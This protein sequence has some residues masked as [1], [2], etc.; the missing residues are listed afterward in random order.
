M[1]EYTGDGKSAGKPKVMP[2]AGDHPYRGVGDAAENNTASLQPEPFADILYRQIHNILGGANP[3]QYLCL[4]IPGQALSAEDFRYDYKNKSPKGPS[5]EANESRLANKMFDPCRMAGADNGLT[6]PYQYQS[7]L[8]MLTPMLN[9]KAADA[10]SKLR[11]LLM[12]KYDYQFQDDAKQEYT[13]QEVFF[14]LY[15]EWLKAKNDWLSEQN[16]KKNQLWQEHS[17]T[18][19]ASK[20]NELY[21]EWYEQVAESRIN[22]LNEKMAKVISVFTPNDMEI[23]EGVLD[24]GSGAELQ[25]ARQALLNA[26]KL[27][28]DGGYVYPVNLN[29]ANWFEYLDTSFTADDLLKNP[30][31]VAM[32][33]ANLSKR[34]I[35][36][37]SKI[38]NLV[39]LIPDQDSLKEALENISKAQTDLDTSEKDLEAFYTDGI[40]ACMDVFA[41]IIP[42]FAESGQI[43]PM[44]VIRKIAPGVTLKDSSKTDELIAAFKDTN[45]KLSAF[46]NCL[47]ELADAS[48]DAAKLQNLSMLQSMLV[49][50]TAQLK[51]VNLEIRTLHAQML[52]SSTIRPTPNTDGMVEDPDPFELTVAPASVPKGYTQIT[53]SASA[54][55]MDQSS[56][57]MAHA[58]VSTCGGSF[59]FGG[60]SRSESNASSRISSRISDKKTEIQIGMNVT[61][62]GIERGWFQPGVFY[63]TKDMFNVTTQRIAPNPARPYTSMD[64]QRL[65]DM[66]GNMVFPCYPV[67][68]V[69]ARDIS[70]RFIS[71][72]TIS[73]DFADTMEQHASA[74]GSFLFFSGSSASSSSSSASGVHFSS[75]SNSVTLKFDTPQIIGY[76]MEATAADQSAYLDDVSRAAQAGYTTISEFVEKYRQILLEAGKNKN[77]GILPKLK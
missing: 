54:S 20:I 47:Q 33:I 36:I 46:T 75:T 42:A 71:E 77:Q 7:A 22:S 66:S 72:G 28:P 9:A 38:E 14:K 59:L 32:Q 51:E 43:V 13:L 57:K 11:Q 70:V 63:L 62:V 10:K 39:S 65:L 73:S 5:V 76:Y 25:E 23:L 44:D 64:D 52:L 17:G 3:N 37:K 61:K 19:A 35:Q 29:P 68:F 24:S 30:E 50:L 40:A 6:L 12:T 67:A 21:L 41:D 4:T 31:A 26:R 60:Y 58:N 27:T 15:D 45:A 18:D 48:A 55:S 74:G 56:Q 69:L 16:L 34:K 2:I 8:N 53:L 49:P 1:S